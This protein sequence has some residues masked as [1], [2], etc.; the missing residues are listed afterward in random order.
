MFVKD[1]NLVVTVVSRGHSD[2]VM[3]SAKLAGA[4]GAT[5]IT[6]RGNSIHETDT[7]LGVSIQPEKEIVLVLVRK[8]IRKKVMRE[9]CKNSGLTEEGQ[10]LCFSMPV[11]EVGGIIHLLDNKKS[12]Q[13]EPKREVKKLER[14]D[15]KK[16]ENKT[17]NKKEENNPQNN[18][19]AN[20]K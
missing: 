17:E 19:E 1:F 20:N 10:G 12:K 7:V 16:Q 2:K 8:Q 4:E 13:T 9:I 6:G 3:E 5:I 11:D 14:E 18:S 15:N